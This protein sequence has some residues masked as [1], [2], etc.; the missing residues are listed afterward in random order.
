[1]D[2]AARIKD[3]KSAELC[4][5]VGWDFFAFGD[6]YCALRSDAR[7]FVSHLISRNEAKF[8]LLTVAEAS[9]AIW[10]MVNA[11]LLSRAAMQL[12]RLKSIGQPFG[13]D[14][15]GLDL[16]NARSAHNLPACNQQH[17]SAFFSITSGVRR[18][19]TPQ[20]A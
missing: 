1:M 3:K 2:Q 7:D 8:E 9:R 12:Y 16:L 6:S 15:R 20:P 17:V 13:T 14:M 18:H 4:K 11:A 10:S 5:V 19:R